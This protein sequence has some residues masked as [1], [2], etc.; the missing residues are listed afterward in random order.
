MVMDEDQGLD[1]ALKHTHPKKVLIEK[2]VGMGSITPYYIHVYKS[3][4][5][6]Q[7]LWSCFAFIMKNLDQNMATKYFST[8]K[9]AGIFENHPI[10]HCKLS[11]K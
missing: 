7:L 1:E 11:V 3:N 6:Q 10:M 4:K 9:T 8:H 2:R 5:N